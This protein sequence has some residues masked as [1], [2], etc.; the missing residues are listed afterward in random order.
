MINKG[1]KILG[2]DILYM[3]LE[4]N[5]CYALTKNKT[6]KRCS[7]KNQSDKNCIFCKKHELAKNVI[8]FDQIKNHKEDVKPIKYHNLTKKKLIL[9]CQDFRISKDGSKREIYDRVNV[10]IDKIEPYKKHIDNILKIQYWYNHYIEK[11]MN[12]LKGVSYIKK[13][14]PINQHDFLSFEKINDIDEK[15]LFIFKDKRDI[16]YA[17][18][19]R[20]LYKLLETSNTNPYTTIQFPKYII[21]IIYKIYNHLN[22]KNLIT[23]INI[24]DTLTNEQKVKLLVIDI[25]IKIDNLDQY[26]DPEWFLELNL[27]KLHL[28]YK[29]LEDIWNYRLSLTSVIKKKI[30]PPDGKLFKLKPKQLSLIKNKEKVQ[31]ICIDV[32]NKLIS[33]AENRTDRINGS[34]YVLFALVIVS[35]KAAEDLPIYYNMVGNNIQPNCE[36][37]FFI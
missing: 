37:Y 7:F 10:L 24:E 29:E 9:I 16:C 1:F 13:F 11:L 27:T 17:F 5:R 19:I 21:K 32:I 6:N 22:I 34:M 30:L 26:T 2:N 14:T 18:D 8:R 35:K 3:D 28:F 25:F 31:Y 12:K 23:N 33:S 4:I 15:L 20:S 36:S